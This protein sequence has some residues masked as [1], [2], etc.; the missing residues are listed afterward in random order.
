MSIEVIIERGEKRAFASAIDW[1]GWAR[2]AKT[3]DEAFTALEDYIPRYRLVAERADVRLPTRVTLDVVETVRGSATTDFG[4]P[5]G[6]AKTDE[7]P[8]TEAHAERLASLLEASWAE[9]DGVA[10]H[11]PEEL[12]K[13]PRGGG[14]DRTRMLGHV[15]DAE[16]SYMRSIGLDSINVSPDD[17]TGLKRRRA[18]V[19]DAF[20]AARSPYPEST[21]QVWPYR[22]AARRFAWHVLDHAWEME[23][24]R[25]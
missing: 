1:P 19:A 23:D 18:I 5:D 10:A 24:R 22:Y 6:I 3:P 2:G 8:L 14:R 9:L 13:G 17:A 15:F 7:R 25:P 16:A 12:T 20:R 21:R 11:S 4:A